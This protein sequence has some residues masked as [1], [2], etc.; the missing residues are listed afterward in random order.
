MTPRHRMEALLVKAA[1]GL[2]GR[3]PPARAARL[4]GGIA[5]A[6]GPLLP[7][8]RVAR[9]NLRLAMPEQDRTA[10][11]RIVRG[12]WWNLGCTVAEMPHLSEFRASGTAASYDITG[13]ETLRWL[14]AKGGPAIF[15]SGHIGNWELLAPCA[16]AHGV[17]LAVLYRAADN[18][19]VDELTARFRRLAMGGNLTM[20]PKGASG[21]RGAI[22]HLARG[23]FIAMLA[24]QKMNDGIE[25]PLFGH[26]AMTAPA[27]AALALRFRC[28]V[29]PAHTE[30]L[31]PARIRVIV[32]PPLELPDSGDRG[33]DIAA[34]TRA[35]NAC[36][37]RWIRARPEGWLWLHRRFAK[38][39]YRRHSRRA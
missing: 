18:P 15:F 36:L 21:A 11:R 34:L 33:A 37:E 8:S 14:T 16:A 1:F 13:T 38:E 30:R 29:I 19:A 23:G 4:A 22:A 3:L 39:I 25:V 28:P 32:E 6:I 5:R 35:V 20:L 26:P 12:L 31:G 10:R 17:R 7:V 2:L 24:D 9:T 27:V